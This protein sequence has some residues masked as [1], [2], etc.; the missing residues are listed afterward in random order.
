MKKG[1]PSRY[2]SQELDVHKLLLIA[3]MPILREHI[4]KEHWRQYSI[5]KELLGNNQM[6]GNNHCLAITNV[7]ISDRICR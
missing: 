1:K 2:N 4:I 5:I 6:L 3:K 7:G